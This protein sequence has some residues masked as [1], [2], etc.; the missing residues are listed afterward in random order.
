MQIMEG[1]IIRIIRANHALIGEYHTAG[2]ILAATNWTS[3][4]DLLPA[5]PTGDQEDTLKGL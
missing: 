5:D 2:L 3:T 1:D 4:R